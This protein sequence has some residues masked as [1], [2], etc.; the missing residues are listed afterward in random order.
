MFFNN[1][2]VFQIFG[3]KC[4]V[5]RKEMIEIVEVQGQN[6][7]TWIVVVPVIFAHLGGD[8]GVHSIRSKGFPSQ[9]MPSSICRLSNGWEWL[10]NGTCQEMEQLLPTLLCMS[11]KM[12]DLASF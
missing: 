12:N 4:S 7:A 5:I 9:P 8:A 10:T 1:V 2:S 6:Q 3:I 11:L